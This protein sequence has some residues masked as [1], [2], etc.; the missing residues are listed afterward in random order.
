MAD[1]TTLNNG[2]IRREADGAII[3]PDPE[4]TD[5]AAYLAWQFAGGV[6]DVAPPPAPIPYLITKLQIYNRMT[7]A[8]L[9]QLDEFVRTVATLRQ[10]R[11]WDDLVE[12]A[13]DDNALVSAVFVGLYGAERTDVLL[14]P[15][16]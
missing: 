1:Y 6:P 13:S 10:R 11:S 12:I 7:D 2:T 9:E 8:E 5:Y 16:T 14:A 15:V 3:P 4:N